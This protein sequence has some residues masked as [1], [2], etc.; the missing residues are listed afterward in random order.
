MSHCV[1]KLITFLNALLHPEPQRLDRL[2]G[3]SGRLGRLRQGALCQQAS[4]GVPIQVSLL[5][6][7]DGTGREALELSLN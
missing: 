4:A 3:M 7:S 2:C 5:L 1:H 6:V